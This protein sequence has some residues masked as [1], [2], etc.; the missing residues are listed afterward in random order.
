MVYLCLGSK[1]PTVPLIHV[2]KSIFGHILLK[3][4]G[5]GEACSSQNPHF[6]TWTCRPTAAQA[7]EGKSQS[8]EG[9]S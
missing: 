9:V 1:S 2:P 7:S 5:Q 4:Y 8:G 6:F 3:A